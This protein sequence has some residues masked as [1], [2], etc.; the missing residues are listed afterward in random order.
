MSSLTGSAAAPQ[1]GLPRIRGLARG[2]PVVA[3]FPRHLPEVLIISVSSLWA[4]RGLKMDPGLASTCSQL[5]CSDTAPTESRAGQPVP[6][7]I[8]L[9]A[10][11]Q[12]HVC[13]TRLGPECPAWSLAPN[14]YTAQ[15]GPAG[16][17]DKMPPVGPATATS[18]PCHRALLPPCVGQA[19]SHPG[20]LPPGTGGN[21]PTNKLGRTDGVRGGLER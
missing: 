21:V 16:L 4:S 17:S 18:L 3:P 8:C 6:A 12:G 7:D 19:C 1:A 9:C 20:P 10:G 2:R 15:H 5:S 13:L 14:G 11:P